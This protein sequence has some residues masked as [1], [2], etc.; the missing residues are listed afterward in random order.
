MTLK[1]LA[2]LLIVG[3]VSLAACNQ[4]TPTT[5][6]ISSPTNTNLRPQSLNNPNTDWMRDAKY[7]NFIHWWWG[8]TMSTSSF[9]TNGLANDLALGQPGY[10]IFTLGQNTGYYNSP[11]TKYNT[12]SGYAPGVRTS[13]RDLPNDLHNALST[14]GIKLMLYL[15]SSPANCD[16]QAAQ[17]FGYTPSVSGANCNDGPVSL[18]T[19]QKWAEVIQEWSDRYGSKVAGWWFDGAY[20]WRFSSAGEREQVFQ[21]YANAAKHGNPNSIVAFNPG[22]GA[23]AFIH[24]T[25]N[26]DYTAGEMV[27]LFGITPS[28]RWLNG[29]QWHELTYLA[30]NWA[31]GTA[32]YNATD[33]GN[34]I[35]N[36]I[37]PN[38]GV[39]TMD[40]A[41]DFAPNGRL[42]QS[43]KDQ[44]TTIRSIVRDG[45]VGGTNLALS[46]PSS[47]SSNFNYPGFEN[48]KANDGNTATGWSPLVSDAQPYWQVDLGAAYPLST[49]QVVTRQDGDQPQTRRNFEIR[50]SNSSDMSNA[51]VLASQGATTLPYQA[52]FNAQISNTTAFRYIRVAKTVSEYFYLSEVRVFEATNLARSAPSSASSNYD[53]F[54]AYLNW[55]ANDGNIA[56][57]WS[58]LVSDARPYWQVDLGA[59]YPLR[60]IEVVTRQDG[61]QIASRRNFE[62]RASNSADMSNSVVLASQGSTALPFQATFKATVASTTPYR[63]LRVAKTVDEYFFISEVRVF[64]APNLALFAPSSVTS[65]FNSPGYENTK[66]NDGSI[67]TGWSP[68]VSDLQPRWQVNLGQPYRLR[69]IELV[70][71]QDGDQIATRRNFEIRASNSADMSNSVVLCSQGSTALAYQATFGCNITNTNTYQYISAGKTVNEYFYI[72]E[73]KVFIP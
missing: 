11:N 42:N 19:A 43:M 54:D 49:I 46:A 10:L 37:V 3:L 26:E 51:V 12:Y 73:L 24:Y 48:T 38:G 62:I 47:V 64:Q 17:G 55:R 68:L 67:A 27:N 45:S 31:N 56:T 59:A 33:V 57:G 41:T 1:H 58:P 53:Y 5:N 18:S 15:P 32:R 66:A 28:S 72:S 29:S 21:L 35:K 16:A 6:G 20:S 63:Y 61:D 4:N 30:A 44:M 14:K 7:G 2:G 50:A 69:R 8:S 9:D 52:T 39:I 22:E 23:G 60:A 34:H 25:D 40:V 71:R 13:S 36:N 70:T 65:N